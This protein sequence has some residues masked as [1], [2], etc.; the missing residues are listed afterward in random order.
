MIVLEDVH[1]AGDPLLD[2]VEQLLGRSRRRIAG[3]RLHRQA[4]VRRAPAGL[5]GGGKHDLGRARAP[6]RRADAHSPDHASPTLAADRAERVIAAAEGNPLFAEHLAALFGDHEAPSGSC[7][8][9]SR[10]C[11][12]RGRGAARARARGRERRSGGR[13]R[14]SGRCCRGARWAGRSAS[15]L[16]RLEQR[17]L[18]EPTAAGRYQFGHA[19]LQEAAYGLIPKGRRSDLHTRLAR[20]LDAHGASDA[21]VGRSP[22]ARLHAA[23]RA[24]PGGRGDG[25]A[26]RGGRGRGSRP[27]GAG[28]TRWAIRGRARLLLER[29]LDLLP[30]GSPGRAAAMIEL[31][32]AGWNLLPERGPAAA[33]RRPGAVLA[34]AARPARRSSCAPGS[35]ASGRFRRLSGRADHQTR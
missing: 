22:G 32:A 23:D 8:A 15:E 28:P 12:P 1:W 26:G 19:L 17:E 7:P 2:V 30:E 13:A 33:A 14:L 35:S 27:R 16:D 31:A 11:S 34:A 6:R 25:A 9:P 3:G 18:I 4:G 5:G 20:W 21:V 10:C 24:R 29:A